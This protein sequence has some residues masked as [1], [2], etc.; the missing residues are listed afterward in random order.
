M[1]ARESLERSTVTHPLLLSTANGITC[2]SL[3]KAINR[4]RPKNTGRANVAFE[5]VCEYT[6]A[7][8]STV[9]C[10]RARARA[11]ARGWLR[12]LSCVCFLVSVG[13]RDPTDAG[14]NYHRLCLPSPQANN[15]LRSSFK[16]KRG[17]F[18]LSIKGG[19]SVK[20]DTRL[21]FYVN[22]RYVDRQSSLE[23]KR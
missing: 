8:R 13:A 16:A 20:E 2:S 18:F 22:R 15:D 3:Q 5:N 21:Q 4:D 23:E 19:G 7:T 9:R 14:G 6:S 1:Y 17:V 10:V 11:R 12:A